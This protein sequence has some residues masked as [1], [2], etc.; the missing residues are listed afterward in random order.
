SVPSRCTCSS[1][2]GRALIKSFIEESSGQDNQGEGR[3]HRLTPVRSSSYA[4]R[5][6]RSSRQGGATSCT[7]IG[8]RAP[9]S[10]NGM[11]H[12]GKPIAENGC[13]NKPRLGRSRRSTP[14]IISVLVPISG[15]LQG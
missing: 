14:L 9:G 4:T 1:A 6:H 15:A 11:L 8:K 7:P 10:H 12:T 5:R 3:R 13:V 2:F